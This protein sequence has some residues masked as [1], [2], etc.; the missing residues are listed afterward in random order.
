MINMVEKK[1]DK[2]TKKVTKKKSKKVTK[3]ETSKPV[4]QKYFAKDLAEKMGIDNYTFLLM[5]RDANI[6]DGSTI[7]MSEMQKLYDKI[8]RR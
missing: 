4:E 1:E 5:K 7:T 6:E 2:K 3:A 8:A